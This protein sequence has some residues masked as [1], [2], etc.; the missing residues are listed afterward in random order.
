M[1]TTRDFTVAVYV[2]HNQKVLLVFHKKLQKW[3]PPGGHIHENELPDEAAL[4]EVKEETGLDIKL[5]GEQRQEMEGV[6]PLAQPLFIQL[7]DIEE[8]EEGLHQHI[9]LIYLAKPKTHEISPS[10]ESEDIRW[11]SLEDLDKEAIPANVR[12]DAKMLI[13]KNL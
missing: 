5:T 11:F 10:T 2:I 13:K 8:T 4:R 1:K 7:E 3:L 12:Y 6:K 9:D